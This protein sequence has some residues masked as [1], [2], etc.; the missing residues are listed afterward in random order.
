MRL[1]KFAAVLLAGLP[2]AALAQ[3]P[4]TLTIDTAKPAAA[5]SP[6][7][8]GLMTEE[9]NYSYDG[10]LYAELVDNRTFQRNRGPS[11][12]RLDHPPERRRPRH[13]GH[14][15]DHRPQRSPARQ[16]QAHR[17]HRRRH[18]PK[19]AS[20]TTATGA[21]PSTRPST[22]H[23]SFY[24][25]ADSASIGAVTIRLVNDNTGAVDATATVPALSTDWKRYEYTLKT[26][27][28]TASAANHLSSSRSSI[29]APPGSR[30]S[31]SSRPPTR[32]APTATAST[33]C[34]SWPPCSRPSCASPAATISKATTSTSASSG[35]R[36]SARSSI[37]PPTPAPGA[38]TPPT[39]WACSNSSSGAK[40]C[41]C[42]RCSPSTPA[43]PCAQEHVD[44]GPALEPYVQDALDE[45][46]YVTG[47]TST[48]WGADPRQGRPSRALPR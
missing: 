47:S 7:L 26:G 34:R 25:K 3:S 20:S 18:N 27:A 36:R 40:T 28:V 19:P 35:R 14:R 21:S 1:E 48:K 9:I 30:S 29:P 4:A 16:P 45:I 24:A 42:S 37:V 44:P 33:S 12:A 22:Y 6:T 43:T 39:A 8:Y 38:T 13:H 23:G 11:V 5:V 10:G 31:R 46:E 32:T 17:R 2:L 41:T 15:Q